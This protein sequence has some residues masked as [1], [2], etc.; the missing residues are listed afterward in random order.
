MGQQ[1]LDL[2][3][4]LFIKATVVIYHNP[5]IGADNDYRQLPLARSSVLVI[6]HIV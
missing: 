4:S 5:I 6:I 2:D 3:I 1:C